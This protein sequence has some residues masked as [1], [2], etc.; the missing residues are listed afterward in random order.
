VVKEAA[1]NEDAFQKIIKGDITQEFFQRA[2]ELE[3]SAVLFKYQRPFSITRVVPA[4]LDAMGWSYRIT[5]AHFEPDGVYWRYERGRFQ[6]DFTFKV[7]INGEVKGIWTP[8]GDISRDPSM[9]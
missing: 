7:M 3:V 1:L 2:G 8:H 6:G 9:D 5:G 4:D